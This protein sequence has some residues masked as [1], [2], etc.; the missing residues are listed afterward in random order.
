[1]QEK[2]LAMAGFPAAG[3]MEQ[4]QEEKLTGTPAAELMA[5]MRDEKLAGTPAP[6]LVEQMQ[7]E[8]LAG[9]LAAGLAGTGAPSRAHQSFSQCK[10][11]P[12]PNANLARS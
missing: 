2:Q 12:C 9:D 4:M 6:G 11:T 3:L 1:M 7:D 10:M 8:Q 5:R